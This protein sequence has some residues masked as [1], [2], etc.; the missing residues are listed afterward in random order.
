MKKSPPVDNVLSPSFQMSFYIVYHEGI[1]P[2]MVFFIVLPF[3]IPSVIFAPR[4]FS[5]SEYFISVICSFI[6]L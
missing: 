5:I 4:F 3:V 2:I 6:L 1:L